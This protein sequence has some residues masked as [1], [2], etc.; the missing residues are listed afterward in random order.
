[1][2]HLATLQG[3]LRRAS[4]A[5]RCDF[6]V[7]ASAGR[8]VRVVLRPEHRIGPATG[9]VILDAAGQPFASAGDAVLCV[10]GFL[11]ESH[12]ECQRMPFSAG[13]LRVF[14]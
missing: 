12:L 6:L 9:A 7:E 3:T 11:P 8:I 5:D 14:E 13:E 1:M 10:G 4:I 2:M